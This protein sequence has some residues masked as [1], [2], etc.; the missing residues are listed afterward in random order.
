MALSFMHNWPDRF[1]GAIL[2]TSLS[3]VAHLSA[4]QQAILFRI[5]STTDAEDKN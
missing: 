5:R 1:A 2:R 4:E 3:V